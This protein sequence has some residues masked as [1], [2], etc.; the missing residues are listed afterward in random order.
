MLAAEWAV[1]SANSMNL[2]RLI[3]SNSLASKDAFQRGITALRKKLPPEIQDVLDGADETKQFY[4]PEYEAAVEVFYNRHL[5]LS[6][7][8]PPK[9]VQAA[10]D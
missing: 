3:I 5:S 10:L 7:P 9:E 8:W 2:R 6:R 4:T 1:K